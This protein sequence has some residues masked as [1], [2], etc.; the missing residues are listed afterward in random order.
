ML[1]EGHS[2]M[3]VPVKLP[4]KRER[5]NAASMLSNGLLEDGFE[6]TKQSTSQIRTKRK[7]KESC[8]YLP[9]QRFHPM[10]GSEVHGCAPVDRVPIKAIGIERLAQFRTTFINLKRRVLVTVL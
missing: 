8:G 7:N 2:R 3:Y 4:S 10:F 1:S 6:S 9:Q 5:P